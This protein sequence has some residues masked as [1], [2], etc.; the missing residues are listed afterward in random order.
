ML[1]SVVATLPKPEMLSL[2]LWNA[3]LFCWFNLLH[4]RERKQHLLPWI[5]AMPCIV[6]VWVNTHGAFLLAAPFLAIVT[7]GA[8]F[9]LPRRAAWHMAAAAA[10]CGLLTVA[11]PYGLRY[12]CNFS[13]PR[14]GG[15]RV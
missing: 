8:F 4:A 5:Y 11:N 10:L 15:R 9:V 2:V 1:A 7:A 3:L 14:W 13:M 12:P 6:L